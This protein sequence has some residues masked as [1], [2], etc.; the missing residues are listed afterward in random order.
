MWTIVWLGVAGAADGIVANPATDVPLTL[1][2]GAV[3]AGLYFGPERQ[4]LGSAE[5]FAPPGGIDALARDR[6]VEP[7]D[8]AADAV[9]NASIVGGAAASL[10][11]SERRLGT[12]LLFTEA[13]MVDGAVVEL[14]KAA[15]RRPRPYTATQGVE[16][17]E[18]LLSFPSGHTAWVGTIGFFSARTFD[19]SHDL[20]PVELGLAYGTA[21]ALTAGMGA[22]RVAAGV[23]HPSDVLVGGLIGGCIGWLVPELHRGDRVR[24]AIAAGDGRATAVVV[25]RW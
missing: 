13:L 12:L 18:D 8:R 24:V 20:G 10:L 4:Q 15:V 14:G 9:L 23:H 2:S 25:G 3:W 19:L 11:V 7:F 17:P 6:Y 21:G 5:T 16:D 1:A 22:L